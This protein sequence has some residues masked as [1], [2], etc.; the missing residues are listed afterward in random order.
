MTTPYLDQFINQPE[1]VHVNTLT[2]TFISSDA[3]ADI[4]VDKLSD[5]VY[6]SHNRDVSFQYGIN[7]NFL[8]DLKKMSLRAPQ[9]VTSG[10]DLIQSSTLHTHALHTGPYPI[11][12]KTLITVVPPMTNT[13]GAILYSLSEDSKIH[14]PEIHDYIFFK[15]EINEVI[16]TFIQIKNTLEDVPAREAK[17]RENIAVAIT[18][19]NLSGNSIW[20]RLIRA[21]EINFTGVYEDDKKTTLIILKLLESYWMPFIESNPM[22]TGILDESLLK[23]IVTTVQEVNQQ[24]FSD[25]TDATD[26]ETINKEAKLSHD[27]YKKISRLSSQLREYNPLIVGKIEGGEEHLIPPGQEMIISLAMP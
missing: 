12:T 22:F 18:R 24:P 2:G 17:V 9:L 1:L 8:R 13:S 16:R 11:P 20:Q 25:M 26:M 14:I 21:V 15:R 5:A 4:R 6:A 19:E 7:T 23:S 27:L 3:V 10:R